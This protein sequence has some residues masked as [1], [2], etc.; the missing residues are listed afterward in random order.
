MKKKYSISIALLIAFILLG[1]SIIIIKYQQEK[2]ADS[3]SN[4]IITMSDV[5]QHENVMP[6]VI[7]GSGCA[8]LS[9]AVYGARS[10][11]K[12]LVLAGEQPGGQLTKTTY[13]ENWPGSEK[14]LGNEIIGHLKK[15]AE[16]FGALIINESLSSLD[17]S[18]WP[19]TLTTSSGATIK[20]LTIVIATGASPKLLSIPGEQEYFGKGVTTCAI[21]D[22]PFHKNKDVI[23]VGGG[24]SA[25]EEAIQLS[26]YAKT[27]TVAVRRDVMRASA[28][29]QQR[30][31]QI[32]N[33]AILY[34]SYISDIVGNGQE[35]TGVTL[36]NA[37]THQATKKEVSGVFLA[38]GHDPNSAVFKGCVKT[39]QHG[40]IVV[41]GRTQATSQEAIF[42]A[43]DVEDFQYRQAGVAAGSGIK[44]AL[45]A[46]DFLQHHGFTA[47]LA[48]QL[49]THYFIPK[50]EQQG[51]L[52][53]FESLEQFKQ[54][55]A[56]TN[57]F[58]ILDFYTQ[59]C[60]S[61]IQMMPAM[62][63]MAHL[64]NE[65]VVIAKVDASVAKDLAAL[66]HVTMVPT[67]IVLKN[68]SLVAR[69]NS[70]MNKKELYE[71]I[72][73]IVEGR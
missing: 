30:L 56:S 57:K 11:I 68:G 12:T 24:D 19:Y 49:T 20:A 17:C 37:K 28:H 70:A 40:Y 47:E 31:A 3:T 65:S 51:K 55:S 4:V 44:A 39:D 64:F 62:G 60:P 33:I 35:V 46:V 27:V 42:A 36:V 41:N 38:I 15:Q 5:V 22:A 48:Q 8:G 13:V 67:I 69:Y 54:V 26:P 23:V 50:H 2:H 29:M 16:S 32:P 53:E 7:V 18:Q 73:N 6:I 25:A 71:F 34:D 52:L 61:C 63:V 43:G 1:L 9:A 59:M 21:C 72:H 10:N 66:Y 14:I 58:I 45:D